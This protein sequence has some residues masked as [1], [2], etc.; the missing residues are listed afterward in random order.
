MPPMYYGPPAAYPNPQGAPAAGPSQQHASQRTKSLASESDAPAGIRYTGVY[1]FFERLY[2]SNP[3]RAI[4]RTLADTLLEQEVESLWEISKLGKD[5]LQKNFN[6]KVG[7]ASFVID[8][9]EREIK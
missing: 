4:L 1:E 5:S 8:E 6:M 7:T 9:V 3:N 2:Q